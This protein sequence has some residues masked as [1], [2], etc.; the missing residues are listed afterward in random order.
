MRRL[1]AELGNFSRPK[2]NEV[3]T[4]VCC[5]RKL[6]GTKELALEKCFLPVSFS[7]VG[8]GL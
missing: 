8:G 1:P 7:K 4:K 6:R 5:T 3:R 2:Q